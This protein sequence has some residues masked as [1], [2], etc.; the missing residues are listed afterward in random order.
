M[1][2]LV[3]T[4]WTEDIPQVEEEKEKVDDD[5]GYL[6]PLEGFTSL[7][8]VGDDA[9]YNNYYNQFRSSSATKPKTTR[10]KKTTSTSTP[11]KK[12]FYRKFWA[13]KRKQ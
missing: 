12:K 1:I 5:D 10:K 9:S 6:S 2:D 4:P 3:E 11:R 8:D 13:K 7:K